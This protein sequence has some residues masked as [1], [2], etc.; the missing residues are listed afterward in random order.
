MQRYEKRLANLR[1]VMEKTNLDVLLLTGKSN[2]FYTTGVNF[3]WQPLNVLLNSW[4]AVVLT[5]ERASLVIFFA[6]MEHAMNVNWMEKC[7]YREVGGAISQVRDLIG[8]ARCIGVEGNI[9]SRNLQQFLSD[10]MPNSKFEDAEALISQVRMFKT[11]DEIELLR[12]ASKIA[13]IGLEAATKSVDVDVPEY[14]VAI[15]AESAMGAAKMS[16]FAFKTTVASGKRSGQAGNWLATDAKIPNNSSIWIDMG[17]SYEG[18][19]SDSTR[20]VYLGNVSTELLKIRSTVLTARDLA[21]KSVQIGRPTHGMHN[22]VL[23]VMQE[24]G[25]EKYMFH[26][27]HGLGIDVVEPPFIWEENAPNFGTGMTFTIEIGIHI[28]DVGG[29]RIED[30]YILQEGCLEKL[31]Q[32]ALP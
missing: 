28:P 10:S 17:P 2:I 7:Q 24:A 27:S 20:T 8:S 29:Y 25:Y 19:A 14:E 26:P 23:R 3:Y 13:D 18:Y 11:D 1:R 22:V 16:D 15:A 30:V 9:V 4:N 6:E 21:E 31:T 32:S 12:V 5:P